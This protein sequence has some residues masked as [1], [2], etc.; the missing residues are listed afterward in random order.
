MFKK[1]KIRGKMLSGFTAVVIIAAIIGLMGI[2][3]INALDKAL[4]HLYEINLKG[5]QEISNIIESFHRSRVNVLYGF[6]ERTDEDIEK[7]IQNINKYRKTIHEAEERFL[8]L[9]LNKKTKNLVEDYK[10]IMKQYYA[11]YIKA[12]RTNKTDKEKA[13]QL[14]YGKKGQKIAA[15][16]KEL[17]TQIDDEV[18]KDA[19]ETEI[20]NQQMALQVEIAMAAVLIIGIIISFL[21]GWFLSGSISKPMK[22]GVEFCDRVANKILTDDLGEKILNRGDEIGTLARA[23][24]NVQNN[25]IQILDDL[26]EVANS[27]AASSEEISASAQNLADGAQNQAANVEETSASMEELGAAVTQVAGNTDDMN[28]KSGDLLNTARQSDGL[29]ESAEE[30]MGKISQSSEQISEILGVINDISD[31]T[32]LLALN[33]AIEAARAGEHGRG[34]AV[35]ADEISKLADKSTENA[36]EI[37]KLITQ[38][39]KDVK[40]GNNIVIRAGDAFKTIIEG[41]EKSNALMD[42]ISKAINQQKAGS[43]QVQKAVEEINEITQNTSASA[44]EMAAST[45][46]L[47]SQAESIK[48]MIDAFDLPA[49]VIHERE[50]NKK[51]VTVKQNV[52]TENGKSPKDSSKNNG[53]K[54][55]DN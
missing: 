35:V 38:S 20:K 51:S 39:M 47:Q 15:K 50:K 21:I 26:G 40:N 8:K 54:N 10:K 22:R 25:L 1:M 33:A 28:E 12:I 17:I 29:I 52:K 53:K 24:D 30:S 49:E 3:A 16:L 31:Q 18:N 45:E 27:L 42:D 46:E 4:E 23:I 43:G 9:S 19:R 48:S 13:R 44:E 55:G 37:E 34:F 7:R 5:T 41:I 6:V 14:L 36:K 32:N 2:F 11:Y